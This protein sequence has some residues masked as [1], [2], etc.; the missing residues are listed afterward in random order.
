MKVLEINQN[1]LKY[2]LEQIKKH[3][4]NS[5]TKIIA[6]VKANGM[7]LDL[8]KYS[9]FLIE[10][11]IETLAVANTYEAINLREEGITSEILMLSEVYS[12]D[13]LENLI[14]N[15]IV[16]TIGNLEEKNKIENIAKSK[17]KCV[18]AHLKVDTGFARFGFV[19][20]DEDKILEAVESSE[21]LKITGVYTHFSKPI[22]KKWT[23]I[24]FER[25][26]ALI[27]KIKN[28]N[29]N[30]I[31]H[32]SSST[33]MILYPEMNLDAVRLGS[34]IQ[35][36]VLKNLLDLKIIGIFKSEIITIKEIQK[37]YNISYGNTFKAKKDM[38]IA[39]IPVRIYGWI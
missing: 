36:R 12:E 3:I 35:G 2:N 6:V 20:S 4:D 21:N 28:I 8:I 15:D 32:C 34:C 25:F 38:K 17:G 10:N 7:G 22:D 27:P 33:A 29:E 19:Y 37:G 30:V 31:F 13:E 1:D 11:G 18:Q 9:K 39:V 24:Q 5:K 16:L 26:K 14:D 23:Y